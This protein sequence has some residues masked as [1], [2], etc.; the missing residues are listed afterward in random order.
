MLRILSSK[1][2]REDLN[3]FALPM[4]AFE[5]FEDIEYLP[6]I[7][8]GT[9]K[10]CLPVS[11][12]D[13]PE[14]NVPAC[15][16][17]NVEELKEF[18]RIQKEQKNKKAFII[19]DFRVSN[20][21]DILYSGVI[22]TF[23]KKESKNYETTTTYLSMTFKNPIK[24]YAIEGISP[25]DL[26]AD[27]MMSYEHVSSEYHAFPKIEYKKEGL[28]LKSI[29]H[30]ILQA[31]QASAKIHEVS[32]RYDG[33]EYSTHTLFFIDK[34]HRIN[35]YEIVGEESFLG[36]SEV[37]KNQLRRELDLVKQ[38]PEVQEKPKKL[39]KERKI[40]PEQ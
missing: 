30:L 31:Y 28:D 21:D 20:L 39:L 16:S 10:F 9:F 2:F 26:P 25:R 6:E 22:S 18:V 13:F 24:T 8:S 23:R 35:L 33:E 32:R 12:G 34:A 38:I 15:F 5:D 1:I 3:D 17:S 19:S 11:I 36:R 37:N 4:W 40:N 29:R 14:T 7:N 27:I